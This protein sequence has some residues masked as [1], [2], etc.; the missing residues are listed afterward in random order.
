VGNG[1]SLGVFGAPASLTSTLRFAAISAAGDRTCARTLDG[2]AYCW[3]STWVNRV[4]GADVRR[5]QTTPARLATTLTFTSVT[6]GA[7]TSCGISA[8]NEAWCWEA[9]STGAIGNGTLAGSLTPSAVA[10]EHQ[11]VAVSAGA[12]HTCAVAATGYAWCWGAGG[13]GELGVSTV[14]LRSRCGE[15]GTP[16]NL[17]PVQVSGWR[18]FERISVGQ[19]GHAC[20]LTLAGNIY[21]WGRGG[22]GQRG[23]GRASLAEWSP[24]RTRP[25]Q[26]VPVDV[27]EGTA[28]RSTWR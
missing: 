26:N 15:A 16:C 3:G 6:A 5:P 1:S 20:G 12:E 19:G 4:S 9:N 18:Q 13:A 25:P 23:D 14:F 7:Q 11:F 17:R 21:C 27:T 24:V 2:L 10:G 8:A 22:M 28:N